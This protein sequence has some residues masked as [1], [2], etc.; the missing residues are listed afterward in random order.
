MSSTPLI[1][2]E[3][4]E[5]RQP[6][7][8]GNADNWWDNCNCPGQLQLSWTSAM[9][10]SLLSAF[11]DFHHGFNIDEILLPCFLDQQSGVLL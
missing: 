3:P 10:S 8:N 11:V 4:F 6:K 5:I 9:L 1:V 7:A 2:V